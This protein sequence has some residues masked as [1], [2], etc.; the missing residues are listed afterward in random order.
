MSLL[1]VGTCLSQSR[2]SRAAYH[3]LDL[4]RF[5]SEFQIMGA[6]Y[7]DT[8]ACS[9]KQFGL[10]HNPLLRSTRTT[11]A[12]HGR[13]P[14]SD[15]CQ[16]VLTQPRSLHQLG[17]FKQ[18][19]MIPGGNHVILS[20]CTAPATRFRNVT[21]IRT[22]IINTNYDQQSQRRPNPHIQGQLHTG[23]LFEFRLFVHERYVSRATSPVPAFTRL[24]RLVSPPCPRATPDMS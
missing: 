19:P 7:D 16:T 3:P 6:S 12:S 1:A 21:Q 24:L 13:P 20:I 4:S 5:P 15:V 8:I 22:K 2:L 14:Q 18:P 17:T 10:V 9:L 23:Y 11:G